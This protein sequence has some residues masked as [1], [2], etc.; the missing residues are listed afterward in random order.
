VLGS[1]KVTEN[2]TIRQ[3][4]YEFLLVC[5]C[6]YRFSRKMDGKTRWQSLLRFLH[7]VHNAYSLTVGVQYGL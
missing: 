4:I 5:H 2:G 7:P 3:I 1:F 6:K